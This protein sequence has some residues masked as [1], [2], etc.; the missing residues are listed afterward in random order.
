[1]G[2]QSLGIRSAKKHGKEKSYL[3][4][5]A[6]CFCKLQQRVIQLCGNVAMSVSSP[7]KPAGVADTAEGYT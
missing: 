5:S 1:M 2:V 3:V 4:T 7:E 6:V